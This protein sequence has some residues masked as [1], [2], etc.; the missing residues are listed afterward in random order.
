MLCKTRQKA[1]ATEE[2]VSFPVKETH[3]LDVCRQAFGMP[4]TEDQNRSIREIL[5]SMSRRAPMTR[6]LQGDV[7]TG[8]TIV[9]LMIMF[10][11]HGAGTI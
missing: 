10:N 8:K 1:A 3:M 11:C 9:A 6:I 2:D 5:E 4:L 7:G